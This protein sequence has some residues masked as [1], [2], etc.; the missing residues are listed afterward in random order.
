MILNDHPQIAFLDAYFCIERLVDKND[1]PDMDE[2]YK[3]LELDFVFQ[4]GGLEI[5]RS[6]NYPH[7]ADSFLQQHLARSGMRSW[8]QRSVIISTVCCGSG[9][10]PGLYI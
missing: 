9:P 10:T 5:D 1:W 2:Y 8:E 3:Y 6:L 7:L 4:N